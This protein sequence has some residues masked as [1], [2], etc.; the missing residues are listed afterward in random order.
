MDKISSGRLA[1]IGDLLGRTW[2]IYRKRMWT[3]I[4]LGLVTVLLTILSLVPPFGLGF[5]LW[6][7]MPDYKNVIMLASILLATGSAVWVANWG[8]SAFLLGV[9]NERCGIKEALEK[10]KPKTLAHMW[11]GLLTGLILTGAHILLLIPG[12][13]FA[14]WFFF[15][16][17]VFIEDDARG[18]NALLKSKAY[19]QGRWFAVFW[20]L[21][22]I[23]LLTVLVAAIPIAGQVLALFFVPFSF[24]YTFLVY[25]DLKALRGSFVFKPSKKEKASIIATGAFGCVMPVVLVFAFMGSMCL[26]PFS[27]LTAKVTGQSPFPTAMQELKNQGPG[28]GTAGL[29]VTRGAIR[30]D[31]DVNEQIQVLQATGKE[32]MKR[33]QAAFKLGQIKDKKAIEP[34]IKALANDEHWT[35]RQNAAR[36]L[37]ALGARQAVPHLIRAL[38]SDKNVFVRTSAAKALGKLGDKSAV[39]ALTKALKDE[40][41]VTTFKDGKGVEVKEAAN[42]AQQ[43]LK[44]LGV[45]AGQRS[46]GTKGLASAAPGPKEEKKKEAEAGID[47]AKNS[48]EEKAKEHRKT[49]KACNKAI[50]MEPKDSLAYHNRAVAHLELGNYQQAIDDFTKALE[51]D[52]NNATLYYNRAIAYGLFN[53]HKQAIEDGIKAVELDPNNANAYINRGIDYIA[54]DN[55]DR[56][57]DDF[58]KAIKFN[59]KDASVYYARGVAYH[60]LGSQKQALKDFNKAAQLGSKMAQ[61]YLKSREGTQKS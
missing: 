20:R 46:I 24:V 32:W 34:L 40:G 16:P 31:T 2:T 30:T 47:T 13:I 60:R 51:F 44:L 49:I 22:A 6:Q 61:Q 28:M 59:T 14:I 9:V 39:A 56:A 41:V 29:T 36:S 55:C 57:V 3:L 1:G 33:S 17:F 52:P 8:M 37:T 45:Q 4:G 23:W 12:I 38:E 19:V 48:P 27:V 18:M 10:A 50:E 54:L 53:K 5:L 35:V 21:V 26:M 11:L 58:T 7:Y 43:A 42:A 25:Q 15:A